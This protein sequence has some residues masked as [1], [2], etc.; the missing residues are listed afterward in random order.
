M[1]FVAYLKQSILPA[2]LYS[3]PALGALAVCVY[4]RP[5]QTAADFCVCAGVFGVA[6]AVSGAAL[7]KRSWFHRSA[8]TPLPSPPV[9]AAGDA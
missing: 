9:G 7:L 4:F 6:C 3:L 2:V 5:A 8:V 1:P